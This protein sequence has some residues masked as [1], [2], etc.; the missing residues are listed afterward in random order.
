MEKLEY[1]KE[2]VRDAGAYVKHLMS[3]GLDIETKSNIHDFVTNVDKQTEQFLINGINATYENQDFITEEKMTQT[4]GLSQMWIIDPIDGTTNFIFQKRNFAISVAYYEDKQPVFGIVYDVMAD[5]MYVGVSGHG[6]SVNGKKLN[7][8]SSHTTLKDAIVNADNQAYKTF[9]VDLDD[10]I[11]TQRY[12]GS[13]ALEI[14]TIA[15]GR[16]NAYISHRLKPWDVAAAVIVLQEA[17]G[18]W[19]YGDVVDGIYYEDTNGYFIGTSNQNVM[20]SLLELR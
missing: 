15:A 8:L 19:C 4:Q 10:H 3:E 11:M 9:K 18:T 1:A 2:L 12:L 6:A 14:V 13:A 16:T 5:E 17:G 7:H 20:S